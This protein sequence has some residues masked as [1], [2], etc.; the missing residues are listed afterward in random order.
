MQFAALATHDRWAL[1][2]GLLASF[3]GISRFRVLHTTSIPIPTMTSHH[4]S[5]P[6]PRTIPKTPLAM[7]AIERMIPT[8]TALREY[9]FSGKRSNIN[10]HRSSKIATPAMNNREGHEFHSCRFAATLCDPALAAEVC[11]LHAPAKAHLRG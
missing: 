8:G 11:F 5:K 2:G 7:K 3:A 6:F 10:I 4:P 1:L 9:E